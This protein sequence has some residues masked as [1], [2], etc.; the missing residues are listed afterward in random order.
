MNK[1]EK[2]LYLQEQCNKIK[3]AEVVE[4]E[5][6]I[7]GDTVLLETIKLRHPDGSEFVVRPFNWEELHIEQILWG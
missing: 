7:K 3:G 1:R 5:T 4:L 6:K 2:Q